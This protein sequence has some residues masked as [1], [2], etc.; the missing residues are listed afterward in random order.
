MAEL[1]NFLPICLL[2]SNINIIILLYFFNTNV[3]IKET[4]LYKEVYLQCQT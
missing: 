3:F 2:M 1:V 4:I